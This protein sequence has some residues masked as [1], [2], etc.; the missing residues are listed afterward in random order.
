ML[1][2]KASPGGLGGTLRS[3]RQQAG[4][5]LA[6][7]H[8]RTGL[9]LST[10]SKAENNKISL[11]YDKIEKLCVAM[12]IDMAQLV[13]PSPP[14]SPLMVTGRRSI[15]RAGE[16]TAIESPHYVDNYLVTELLHKG[17]TPVIVEPKSRSI[18][19]F[20]DFHRHPGEEYVYVLEGE[21]DFHTEIY[22]PARLAAGD[23]IYFDSDVGHAWIAV[24]DARCR[25]LSVC[26]RSERATDV[27]S[28]SSAAPFII[29]VNGRR[30]SLG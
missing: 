19:N 14:V 2:A 27:K 23:S 25:I 15:A 28:P 9:A 29:D 30:S 12:G 7:L 18:E 4:L 3:Y 24:G 20:D 6:E 5:T 11:T 17:M 13:A 21:V 10:L 1:E 16:G 26:L 8:E 22:A